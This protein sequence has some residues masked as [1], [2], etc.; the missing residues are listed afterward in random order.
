MDPRVAIIEHRL[1]G[2]KRII[3]VASG[4][5]GVGKSVTA[6]LLALILAK[7]GYHVGLLDLDLYG[8]S[9]HIILGIDVDEYPSEDKGIIPPERH[10]IRFMSIVYY[11]KEHPTP[12]RGED[13]TNA[14]IEVLAITRWGNLDFLIIDMP[15][16][17]GDETLDTIRLIKKSEFLV[18]TT[19]SKVALQTVV[20]L[21]KLLKELNVPIIGVIENMKFNDSAYVK[22]TVSELGV[23]YLGYVPFD[24]SFEDAV[25]NAEKLMKTDVA[26]KLSEL[27]G[28]L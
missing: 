13:V 26:K 1:N 22:D 4:K 17:I 28:N 10:G 5:G 8:P 16:G 9:S 18:V 3:A 21:V 24:K 12:L 14:I 6:S 25:G 20:K 7:R 15:P 11:S 2:I 23:K 27:V 19:P